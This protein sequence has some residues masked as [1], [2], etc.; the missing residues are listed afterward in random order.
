M[1]LPVLLDAAHHILDP[2]ADPGAAIL[3]VY[4]DI[5]EPPPPIPDHAAAA[6]R[7]DAARCALDL[8]RRVQPLLDRDTPLGA[9]DLAVLRSLLALLFHRGINPLL[10]PLWRT[11]PADPAALFALLSDPLLPRGVPPQTFI[12]TTILRRHVPDLLR[13]SIT[14]AWLPKSLWPQDGPSLHALR[15][16]VLHLLESCV[17][18]RICTD[19]AQHC[20]QVSPC[21]R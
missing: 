6:P 13:A 15:P 2:G 1:S 9:R 11:G 7:L 3:R 16:S 20:G 5:A 18:M 19:E 17:Y 4:A 8:L 10:A 12:T 14:L 21:P